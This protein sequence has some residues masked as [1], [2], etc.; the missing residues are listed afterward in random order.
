[1]NRRNLLA[2]LIW[3]YDTDMLDMPAVK[4]I[5]SF[6]RKA[7]ACQKSYTDPTDKL[8]YCESATKMS[9]IEFFTDYIIGYA[10]MLVSSGCANYGIY[11][12]QILTY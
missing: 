12:K 9:P 2:L 5:E 1:M 10:K 11:N 8:L 3:A 6:R 4:V 7:V